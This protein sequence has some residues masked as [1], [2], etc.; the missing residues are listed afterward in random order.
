MSSFADDSGHLLGSEPGS[1]AIRNK[2]L[3]KRKE[4]GFRLRLASISEKADQ[5]NVRRVNFPD[6]NQH[7]RR[8]AYVRLERCPEPSESFTMNS[9]IDPSEF[10]NTFDAH[11]SRTMDAEKLSWV[12]LLLHWIHRFAQEM[13]TPTNVQF[14][15]S[16]QLH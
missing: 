16:L 7:S 15:Y 9:R 3:R 8:S 6:D 11:D 1:R 5:T 14:L 13:R 4:R 12:E 10:Q 2:F